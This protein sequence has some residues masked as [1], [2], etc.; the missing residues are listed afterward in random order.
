ME[1][2][3]PFLMTWILSLVHSQIAATMPGSDKKKPKLTKSRTFR[4][5]LSN[6]RK[7]ANSGSLTET[8]VNSKLHSKTKRIQFNLNNA[9]NELCCNKLEKNPK[10]FR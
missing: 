9:G 1:L 5:R 3:V 4:R 7:V 10:T 6:V 2:I 8:L